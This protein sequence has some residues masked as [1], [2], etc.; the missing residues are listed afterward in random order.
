M[1]SSGERMLELLGLLQARHRW[2]G[3]ELAERLE[4]SERTL[5]RDVDRLRTLG[6]PVHADRGL[7]GGYQLGA[8]TKLPPLLLSDD[9]AVAIAVG[10]RT[11]GDQPIAG[12]GDSAMG[13]LVKVGQLLSPT[14]QRQVESIA[15]GADVLPSPTAR[16]VA[17][18]TLTAL[19]RASRD[20]ERVRFD[21]RGW[22]SDPTERHVEPHDVVPLDRR[23]YLLAWDLE[24]D[25][26]RCFRLDRIEDPRSTNRAFA[27][28][29][30]PAVDAT[31]YIRETIAELKAVHHVTLVVETPIDS[32][33]RHIGPWA[34][35]EDLGDG[36]T[37]IEMRIPDLGWAA[38]MLAMTR[39]EIRSVEPPELRSFL[40]VLAHRF[41]AVAAT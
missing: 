11:A 31:T 17:L 34:T 24:R 26:W 2:S 33:R 38:L 30:L 8:G 40:H 9:E 21:Y 16:P 1:S 10:L 25:D 37:R 20:A 3:R 13:A 22:D 41:L 39:A 5:R 14:L 35:A 27:R 4:V 36:A 18:G 15:G 12:I 7:D 28:R 23:W 32:V 29:T 19:A 6:Y